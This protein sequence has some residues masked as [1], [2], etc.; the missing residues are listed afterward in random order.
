MVL[1]VAPVP[2]EVVMTVGGEGLQAVEI[3]AY[4]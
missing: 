1:A 2:A 4:I 3:H